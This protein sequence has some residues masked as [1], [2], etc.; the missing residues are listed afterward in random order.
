MAPVCIS[1]HVIYNVYPD[2]LV[3]VHVRVKMIS[4]VPV[5]KLNPLIGEMSVTDG[6][7]LSIVN[8][9]LAVLPAISYPVSNRN[10]SQVTVRELPEC[11]VPLRLKPEKP[12]VSVHVIIT[13]VL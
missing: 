9:M 10:P 13:S 4:F 8:V 11:H 3:S 7:V 6:L 5:V 1:V 2:I 12:T